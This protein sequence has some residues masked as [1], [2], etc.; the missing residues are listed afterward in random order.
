MKNKIKTL[1][2]NSFLEYWLY[3]MK[4][5]VVRPKSQSNETEIIRGLLTKFG[6]RIKKTFVEFGFS[7]WEY[8]CAALPKDWSG[9]LID[10]DYQNVK[11][12]KVISTN[13]IEI[14]HAWLTLNNIKEMISEWLGSRELGILSI[15]IDGNDYWFVERLIT[16]RPSVFIVEYNST[17]GFRDITIPYDE[18]F[19]RTKA[20]PSWTY[21]GASLLAMQRLLT[22]AG[23][24]L[25][26]I[27]DSGVNA[28][29]VR[30]DLNQGLCDVLDPKV[31]FK[32]KA[33]FDGSTPD[34]QWKQ[35]EHMPYVR[36]NDHLQNNR[37]IGFF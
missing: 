34:E 10:G 26:D 1:I 25:V 33:F 14:V 21:F 31:S 8:N 3:L 37:T 17:L 22:N 7:S 2:K 5:I 6:P 32:P 4:S 24:D 35:I 9:L 30:S 27:S 20:H 23:Y 19:D 18:N 29:F 11:I 15:D 12:G 28:F 36:F 13:R 16:I